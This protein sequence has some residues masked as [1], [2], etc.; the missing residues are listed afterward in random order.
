MKNLA[1]SLHRMIIIAAV[2]GAL[3][4]PMMTR[5]ALAASTVNCTC[6]DGAYTNLCTADGQS[7]GDGQCSCVSVPE[8]SDYLAMAF[9]LVSGGMIYYFRR[10][11]ALAKA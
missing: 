11:A 9:V 10:R 5:E 8:M 4:S 1:Q 2:A 7:C 3:F 6:S